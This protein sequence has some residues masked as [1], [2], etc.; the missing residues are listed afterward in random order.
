MS[1]NRAVMPV[2]LIMTI[3]KVLTMD[4]GLPRA[5]AVAARAGRIVALGAT[6]KIAVL[7]GPATPVIEAGGW[8]LLPGFVE[9][10]RHPILGGA[11]ILQMQF[12]GLR[13]LDSLRAAVAVYRA[14]HPELGLI[15]AQGAEGGMLGQPMARHDLDKACPDLPLALCAMDHHTVWAKTIAL[16]KAGILQGGQT[17]AGH[18][19]AMGP[20]GTATGELREDEAFERVIGLGGWMSRL[21][22]A[23]SRSWQGRTALRRWHGITTMIGYR[24]AC[25]GVHGWGAGQPHGFHG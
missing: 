6:A 19:I 11:G 8:T 2:D 24:R 12:H 13:G 18:I 15:M 25:Q 5:E 3:A 10:H 7:A 9:S 14:A 20:D 16:A 21:P 4:A 23:R 1:S 17:R 22:G